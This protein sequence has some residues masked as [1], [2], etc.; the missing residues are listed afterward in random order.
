MLLQLQLKDRKQTTQLSRQ[1][2]LYMHLPATAP[3]S[4]N[5]L[6]STLQGTTRYGPVVTRSGDLAVQHQQQ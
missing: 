6:V 3:V 2:T 5:V 4:N 1:S